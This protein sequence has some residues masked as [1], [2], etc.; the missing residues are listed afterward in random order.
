MCIR[1]SIYT[2]GLEPEYVLYGLEYVPEQCLSKVKTV[3]EFIY[4]QTFYM[5]DVYKRQ[6][7]QSS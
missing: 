5:Q 2:A 3:K 1:D 4:W 7:W 6:V